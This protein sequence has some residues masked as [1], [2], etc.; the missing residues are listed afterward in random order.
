MSVTQWRMMKLWASDHVWRPYRLVSRVKTGQW[1]TWPHNAK[2]RGERRLAPAV[3]SRK[4]P[5]SPHKTSSNE[6]GEFEIR[7]FRFMTANRVSGCLV[8]AGI[9]SGQYKYFPTRWL[10][11]LDNVRVTH[12]DPNSNFIKC[13]PGSVSVAAPTCSLVSIVSSKTRVDRG[14]DNVALQFHQRD[15]MRGTIFGDPLQV[16]N[17]F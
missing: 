11:M 7:I 10:W 17:L 15:T 16:R 8:S 13:W 2:Y 12:N 9:F 6:T 1:N 3:S 5:C 14:G 4:C